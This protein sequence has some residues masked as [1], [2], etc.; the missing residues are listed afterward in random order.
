[1]RQFKVLIPND[2]DLAMVVSYALAPMGSLN[3]SRVAWTQVLCPLGLPVMD[4][5][6][7]AVD[8]LRGVR[9]SAEALVAEA[10]PEESE[11]HPQ[12]ARVDSCDQRSVTFVTPGGVAVTLSRRAKG[13][14]LNVEFNRNSTCL[15]TEVTHALFVAR[16]PGAA[17]LLAEAAAEAAA[18]EADGAS[19]TFNASL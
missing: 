12:Q 13:L 6:R 4:Y 2:L 1:M 17:A 18:A 5:L 7:G 19:D 9:E 11:P 14:E 3:A 8:P 16:V 15:A 10:V